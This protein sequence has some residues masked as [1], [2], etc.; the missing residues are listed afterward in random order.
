MIYAFG[1]ATLKI[2]ITNIRSM[3]TIKLQIQN[4]AAQTFQIIIIIFLIKI[5][6]HIRN[7]LTEVAILF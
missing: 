1:A 4:L 6:L 7:I 5:M 3:Q 2:M